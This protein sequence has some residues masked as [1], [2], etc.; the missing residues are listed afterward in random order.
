MFLCKKI[1]SVFLIPPGLFFTFISLLAFF[2][3]LKKKYKLAIPFIS[4]AIL[5]YLFSAPYFSNKLICSLEEPYIKAH[6]TKPD[7]IIVLGGSTNN[8]CKDPINDSNI[9]DVYGMDR[10]F[11]AYRLHRKTDLPLIVSGGEVMGEKSFAL[12]AYEI[13]KNLGVK[14]NKIF[15]EDK[16]RDTYE[17]ALFSKYICDKNK[18][19]YPV[20]I[21]DGWHIDRALYLFKKAGFKNID[22]MASSF[23]CDDNV[24]LLSFLPK[25]SIAMRN[26]IYEKLGIIYYKTIYH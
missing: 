22:Y 21:T 4:I 8:L 10:L 23:M 14:E 16:S 6:I 17:N 3:I 2:F 9:L 13:L 1:L 24:N 19:Y 25:D 12:S 11:M 5:F 15:K 18:F 26:Y 7:V 20:I